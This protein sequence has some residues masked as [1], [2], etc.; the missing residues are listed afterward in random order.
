MMNGFYHQN[1]RDAA[2]G[3]G[4]LGMI[5]AL[6]AF[7]ALLLAACAVE[8]NKAPEQIGATHDALTHTYTNEPDEPISAYVLTDP[9]TGI[10]YIVT[11]NGGITPRLGID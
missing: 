11:S 9:D 3:I 5:S 8:S 7:I 10:Q 1:E 4:C 2:V 6:V